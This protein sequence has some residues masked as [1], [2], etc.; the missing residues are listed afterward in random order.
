MKKFCLVLLLCL[1]TSLAF[2]DDRFQ[3]NGYIKNEIG[4]RTKEQSY[5]QKNKN[6]FE[7][8]AQYKLMEDELVLFGKAKYFYDFAYTKDKLDK[9]GHYMQ[10]IQRTEWLRDLYLDY[11]KGPWFLRLGKQQ[12]AWGQSDG[13]AILDRVNPFDLR[14]YWQ[15]DFVDLRIPLW[16]ANINYAPKLNSN[17]QLLFIPDFEESQAAPPGSPFTFRSYTL[18]DNFMKSSAASF[19][20]NMRPPAKQFEHATWGLQWSDRI[21]D[22]DYTLNFL[23]GPYYTARNT[24][25]FIPPPIV[26]PAGKFIVDRAFKLWRVYGGSFN[27]SFT[28]PGPMQGITLRGDFAWYND[29]PTYFG[30]PNAGSS[31]GIVRWN[32]IFWLLG[33]DKYVITKWLVSFQYAQYIMEHKLATNNT[34]PA[35]QQVPLNSYTYGAQ[36]RLENIFSLK[37]STNFM[38]DRLKPEVLWSFTDDNQGKVSPKL[39][40]EIQDNL[41]FTLGWHYFY[42]NETDSNGQFRRQNQVFTQLKYSF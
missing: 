13:I 15:P 30:D 16:M 17:L 41:L 4:L 7:L 18:F 26:L 32:N 22:M 2:A 3:F 21:G 24:T 25:R 40:Y 39:T 6:I 31:K 11:N 19:D 38:N 37:I 5:L 10:H 20:I 28:N 12:V 1:T 27:R 36:D 42:G 14:E 29:E 23:Y 34:F 35:Y 8:A 33:V 9:A